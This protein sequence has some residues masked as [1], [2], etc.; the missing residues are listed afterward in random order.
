MENGNKDMLDKFRE[1]L[2]RT[3]VGGFFLL[4]ES[5]NAEKKTRSPSGRRQMQRES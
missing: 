4:T 3:V 5:R 1:E 2:R